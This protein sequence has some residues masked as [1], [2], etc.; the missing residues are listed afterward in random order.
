MRMKVGERVGFSAALGK[1]PAEY[2]FLI[3]STR[4]SELLRRVKAMRSYTLPSGKILSTE[5][6][7]PLLPPTTAGTTP[8]T[9]ILLHGLGSSSSFYYACLSIAQLQHYRI[10]T[11]DFDGH[12]LSPVSTRTE[13][14][15]AL[16][17]QELAQDL[18]GVLDVMGV[19]G[20]VGIG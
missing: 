1:T 9:L 5:S 7:E 3:K 13:G 15:G 14:K 11:Y 4:R 16:N 8:P 6:R 12:G 10:I 17:V 20:P 18:E 19:T 2:A